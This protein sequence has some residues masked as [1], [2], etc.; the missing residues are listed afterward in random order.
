V[1]RK[2]LFFT[3]L[4]LTT[5]ASA[6]AGPAFAGAVTAGP[7]A[8]SP[9]RVVDL[10]GRAVNPLVLPPGRVATVLVFTTTDCPISS[11]YAPEIQG[12]A[13]KFVKQGIA[14]TLVY[15]VGTD[16][17]N[18][19]REHVKK[20]GYAMPVARDTAQELVK[21]TGVTVTP[22]V[23]VI[24]AGGRVLYKGRIDDRYVEFGMDRPQPTERTLERALDA[25]VQGKPVAVPETRAIGCFLPELVK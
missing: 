18:V 8:P 13:A 20:F 1:G 2:L 21:Y 9:A 23:A 7:A 11:R 3:A 12:L 4:L 22:E 14:F 24:G 15:P 6:V 10:A 17:P 19:I 5:V 25:I 16:T